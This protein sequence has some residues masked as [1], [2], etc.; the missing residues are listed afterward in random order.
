MISMRLYVCQCCGSVAAGL[1]MDEPLNSIVSFWRFGSELSL[2][3]ADPAMSLR[4]A[5][6]VATCDAALVFPFVGEHARL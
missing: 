1:T 5:T 4:A 3:P 6:S 2:V